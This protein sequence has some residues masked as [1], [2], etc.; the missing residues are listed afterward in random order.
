MYWIRVGTVVYYYSSLK[1]AIVTLIKGIDIGDHL[2]FL[3]Q[4]TLLFEQDLT[5]L[6]IN[7][8]EVHSANAGD[9]VEML[10]DSPVEVDTEVYAFK[11]I[12]EFIN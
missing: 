9:T 3:K 10:V 11:P 8:H 5:T 6:H 2:G 12:Q 7:T 4:G 1:I